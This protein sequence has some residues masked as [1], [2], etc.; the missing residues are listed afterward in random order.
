MNHNLDKIKL[1]KDSRNEQLE[2]ISKNY[3]RPLFDVERFIVKEEFIDNGIDFRIELKS[4]SNKLGFG[5]NFQ[6]KSSES[7]LKNKDGSYSKSLETSNI[8]Y[9]LNNGQ[10]AFYGFYI[11]EEDTIYFENLDNFIYQLY[12]KDIDWQSQ[13]NHS[14]R[15]SKKMDIKSID[16]IFDIA[17]NR[18]LMLRNLNSKLAENINT[19][20]S[21][22]NIIIDYKGNVKSDDEIEEFIKKYGLF[23]NDEFRW[24][25][26]L[27]MHNKRSIG[28]K[29]T[30]FY[31]FIIG[32]SYMHTGSY[33]QA[34]DYLKNSIANI[35]VLE[36]DLQ[37]YLI[38]YYAELQLLFGLITKDDYKEKIQTASFNTGIKYYI[39]LDEIQELMQEMYISENFEAKKFEQKITDFIKNEK[40]NKN[41]SFLAKISFASYKAERLICFTPFA[42]MSGDNDFIRFK[43]LE[44]NKNFRELLLEAQ[45]MNS[46]FFSH[47]CGLKH[48]KFLIQFD[49]ICKSK[50]KSYF[51][52][53][54]YNDIKN[55]IQHSYNYF[56]SIGHIQNQ[57]FSL[58]IL[59]ELYQSEELKADEDETMNLIETYAERYFN[60]DLKS[61]IDFIKGGGTFVQYLLNTKKKIKELQDE[62]E[63]KRKELIKLDKIEES[64]KINSKDS[65][66]IHLFPMGYFK[67]P[68]QSTNRVFEI[69]NIKDQ[70]LKDHI[71]WFFNEG[72]IPIVNI[73]VL[74][75]KEE[76]SMNGML[77]YKG[78]ESFRNMYRTRKLFFENKFYRQKMKF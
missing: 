53:S 25:D 66:T 46:V 59:L 22:K 47:Y 38:Y 36:K 29:K 39:E 14:L 58:T 56:L 6:L 62:V 7:T 18:G 67:F 69:L 70:E 16:E 60:P 33:F 61:T 40:L 35:E 24:R 48:N 31:N 34:L 52:A 44:I 55:S 13:L 8:E 77:E 4:N 27:D 74:E 63:M 28:S 49:A 30:S 68:K 51:D 57:L 78:I 75:I 5:F 19:P 21:D 43:F 10:P 54:L 41:I 32:V 26:I 11:L 65:S 50:F 12:I 76:G 71:K 15:F 17:L 1:P 2:T 23:L 45:V 20:N 9:L 64:N 3:F 72:I 37:D 73:Y 42:L